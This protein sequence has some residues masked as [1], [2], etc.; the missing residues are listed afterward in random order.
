[1]V[2]AVSLGVVVKG[3]EGLVLAADSR[4][5]LTTASLALPGTGGGATVPGVPPETPI[6]TQNNTY[7][8][9]ATKLLNVPGQRYVGIVTYG[10]GTI[11]ESEP[12]TAQG[13]MPEFESHLTVVSE[14]TRLAV[15]DAA[16][17]LGTFF[18]QQWTHAGM[19]PDGQPMIFLVGGFDD[20]APYGRVFEVVVPSAPEPAEQHPSE[21][22]IKWGGQPYL[23]ERLIGGFAE[24]APRLAKDELQ[25]SDE[26]V[27]ALKTR[28]QEL[29][30]PIP[31]QFLALQDAVD[32]ATFLVSMTA[33]V[34]TWTAG[35]QPQ[36]VGGQ[37]DVATITRT[38]GFRAVQQ[39]KIRPRR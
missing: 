21:F 12:R 16:R 28:W 36:G 18:S 15:E 4:V 9:N 20:A 25:L 3:P 2:P 31:Y 34:M 13:Y 23:L 5:T 7:F 29:Q 26:Q 27:E 6:L 24:R 11:G 37:I 10:R 22:G 35:G 38:G 19:A 33:E 39:K 14:G 32:L 1:M 8:D 30:L 17:E